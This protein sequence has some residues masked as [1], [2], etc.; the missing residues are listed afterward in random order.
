HPLPASVP[1]RRSSD[2][3]DHRVR[4]SPV[5]VLTNLLEEVVG[6]LGRVEHLHTPRGGA[7]TSVRYRVDPEDLARSQALGHTAG[8]LTDGAQPQ[9]GHGPAFGYVRVAD[10]LPGRGEHVRQVHVAFVRPAPGN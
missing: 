5:R 9:D 6:P 7:Y 3:V 4:S 10:R 8:H 2:L 1:T